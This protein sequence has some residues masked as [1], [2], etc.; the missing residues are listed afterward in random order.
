MNRTFHQPFHLGYPQY[1]LALKLRP[2]QAKISFG[3]KPM[4]AVQSFVPSMPQEAEPPPLLRIS[5]A[6]FC[7]FL[8]ADYS[9]FFEWKL[10]SLHV[11]MLVSTVALAGAAME[12]RLAAVFR[13]KIGMCMT[14]L[15]MLYTINIPFSTWRG[16]SFS[17]F[18]QEWLKTVI[19]FAIAGA[20]IF[21][22]RQCRTALHCIG[23]GSGLGGLLV[24]L[25]GQ[26]DVDGRLSLGAGTFKNANAIAF[27]LL[28]GLPFLWLVLRDPHSGKVKKLFAVCL[29]ASNVFGMVRTG[30]RGSLIGLVLLC[31][32]FFL[33]SSMT[34]KIAMIFVGFMSVAVAVAFMPNNL[35]VR[36]ATLFSGTEAA[37]AAENN[38]ELSDVNSAEGSSA[39]RRRLLLKSIQL[40]L[41][42]PLLGVGLGQFGPYMARIEI[43]QGLH[44]G[45]Q[46]THNTY[47]QIS[48]EAGVPALIVFVCMIVFSIRAVRVLS[49][50]AKKS[51][52][53]RD[54]VKEVLDI[55]FALNASLIFYA[56]CVCFDYIAYSATL[57]ILAGLTIALTRCG[58]TEIERMERDPVS[59]QADPFL[60]LYPVRSA[61]AMRPVVFSPAAGPARR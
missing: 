4:T 58:D 54:R 28:L 1:T 61:G 9:R 42:Y 45:W 17:T 14:I 3:N 10:A 27:D 57:P 30:S 16:G 32:L 6:C 8:I 5:F 33:R 37:Q 31:F 13:S 51:P 35:K 56:V 46:G 20:L 2:K 19:V 55:T 50:R 44:T 34:A 43:G 52:L 29:M 15:T 48:S 40:T 39:E 53:P 18:R 12:G 7:I 59:G 36:Y 11:P 60:N 22:I 24:N 41:E 25:K 26:A 23:F 47:T 38:S 21:N 49:Q